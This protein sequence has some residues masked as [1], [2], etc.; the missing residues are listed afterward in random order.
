M[1][2]FYIDKVI[3]ETD[4]YFEAKDQSYNKKEII[5]L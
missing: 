2:F 5:F 3:A 4:A 1:F